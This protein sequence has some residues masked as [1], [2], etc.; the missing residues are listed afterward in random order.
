L[1]AHNL[2]GDDR[3]PI[4]MRTVKDVEAYL[5]ALGRAIQPIEDD[6]DTF[7]LHSG[8]GAIAIALRV[9]TP[10]VLARVDV[11]E[12]PAAGSEPAFL[13]ALL[14]ANAT[15]LLHTSF[16]ISGGRV[17]L[18]GALRLENLDFNELEAMIDEIDVA[19]GRDVP[20]LFAVHK[21]ASLPPT[22]VESQL[23]GS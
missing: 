11:G 16:G 15:S 20:Q 18:S 14:E 21:R 1:A 12:A 9:N 23:K 7:V 4:P 8:P 2:G 22:G 6:P 10:I 17:V 5:G 13:Q 3:E 19:I